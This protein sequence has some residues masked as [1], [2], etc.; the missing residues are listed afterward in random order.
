MIQRRRPR[1]P[2]CRWL[3]HHLSLHRSTRCRLTRHYHRRPTCST[4]THRLISHH[5][6]LSQPIT[7]LHRL[8]ISLVHY[9]VTQ[10]IR[11]RRRQ[12]SAHYRL[13]IL[14]LHRPQKG[15]DNNRR[16]VVMY[17]KSWVI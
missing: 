14:T 7:A 12:A 11:I 17:K 2:T 4:P 3:D 10:G 16:E 9:R 6:G 8:L 15:P 5:F 1:R 13:S